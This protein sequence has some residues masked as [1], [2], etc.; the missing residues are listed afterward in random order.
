VPF[1]WKFELI[2]EC[3][4]QQ[5]IANILITSFISERTPVIRDCVN[6]D[7]DM[8]FFLQGTEIKIDSAR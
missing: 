2:N 4:I 8:F 1:V 7:G 5:Y 6:G 3:A